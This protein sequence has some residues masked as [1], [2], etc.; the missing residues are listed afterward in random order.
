MTAWW[1]VL[2][3]GGLTSYRALFTWLSPWILFPALIIAPIF[4]IL[5]FAYVGRDAGVE[6]PQ[7]F[8]IGNAIL[9]AAV[10]CL[11]AMGNTI[12]DERHFQTLSLLLVSPARRVP[13]FLGR[14]L[15]VV[16]NGFAVSIVAL[17]IGVLV[18]RV[19]LPPS[20][21][22]PLAAV[23]FVAAFSC[24]GLG[25]VIGALAMRVRET[26]VLFNI[27]YGFMLIFCG[28]NVALTAMP[29]WMATIGS[30]L[31]MT[32]AIQA[33]RDVAAGA[34]WISILPLLWTEALVGITFLAI[35]ILMLRFFEVE[36]RRHSTL[37]RA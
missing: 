11:A 16:L 36:S 26:A 1:R 12:G 15:P 28:V 27:L 4:Q 2:L 30:A 13:L 7:F 31:P 14:A 21:W 23:A 3:R 17:A 22:L 5:F 10:P 18:L 33:A 8:L 37:D 34:T 29:A 6:D 20:T 19:S 24:T 25:L 32:H 9:Y 35:G